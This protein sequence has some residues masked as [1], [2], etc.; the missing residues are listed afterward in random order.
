VSGR[1][2]G[3][4][5]PRSLNLAL[6]EFVNALSKTAMYP[7]GH[8]FIRE[9]ADMLVD[10]LR[11]A[12]VDRDSVTIGILPRGLLLDGTA[13]EP[14]PP[15][16]REFAVRMHRKN[17]GTIHITRG[18]T[19]DEVAALLGGLAPN[20]ADET[21]GREGLRLDHVRVEPMTYDVL[22]FADPL[23]D[24]DLDDLF[25]MAL[26]EAAF[27]RRL[28]E[29]DAMPTA[30]QIA[31]AISERASESTEGA[32]R[33]YEALAGFSAALATR[34]E[35]AS[36]SARHRFVEVLS[37]LSRPTTARVVA[38]APS[39]TS[40]RR[41]LRD[42]LQ[43]VPPALLLQLLETVAEADGEPISPQLRWLLGKLASSDTAAEPT[44]GDVFTDEVLGLVQQWEPVVDD[45][46]EDTDPRFG[47]EPARVLA[48]GLE[49]D[50]A[51]ERVV[52][53]ARRLAER[54]HLIEVLQL[55]DDSQ[56]DVR[57]ARSI[58]DA[59]LDPG[60]LQ[61]LLSRPDLDFRLIERVARHAGVLAADP[62]LDALATATDRSTRRRLLDIL[63]GVGAA[64]E[65]TLLARLDGA[66]WYLARNILTV[67]GQLPAVN[68][69]EP[70]FTALSSSELRV[71]QEAL[72]VLLRQPGARD[73]AVAEAL[74]SG[75]ESLTRMA[76]T[77]LG[78][79][80]PPRLVGA[81]LTALG[82]PVRE[83]Q[84]QAIRSLSQTTNPLVVPHLLPLVRARTG[85]L[86]RTR[87]LP[88][89]PVMLAA[90]ELLARRWSSHRPVLPI[91]Q[92]ASKSGDAEIRA[93]IG[94]RR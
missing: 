13:V 20:T 31:E 50:L 87:L 14:L 49:L 85:F 74:E 63:A 9:S 16:L 60:T 38:A 15:M 47:L 94:G 70:V 65:A 75:E 8:R 71:R 62:L 61:H 86:K 12:M 23:A 69:V 46:D 3:T 92:L 67:L 27:G 39:T 26:V 19:A 78:A 59:V 18:I 44:A 11:D 29:G 45:A 56:N 43:L 64:S 41:F 40:R 79:E 28:S 48:I 53:A 4:S 66:S 88:K 82:N 77:A 68:D 93:A 37:A 58:A 34:G 6:R 1:T 54:G 83:L 17:I 84:V 25:W 73:R 91:M 42:T 52:D 57:V 55:L 21:V 35:H 7:P 32:L 33:A 30:P 5:L 72:K 51:A 81:V 90:L 24:R 89:S 2:R 10:R 80:C 36:R 76:L 22:A